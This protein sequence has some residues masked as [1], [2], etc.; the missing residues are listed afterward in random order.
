MSAETRPRSLPRIHRAWPIALVTFLALVATAAFRSSTG[1]LFEPIEQTFGWSRSVTSSAVTLNLVVYGLAAPFA[2]A[3]M[4]RFG[5]RRVGA[6]ALLLV[7]TGSGLTVLM[8][9]VWHLWVLWGLFIGLGTGA[10]ALVF[11][12]IV[13]NRWF[14][15]HRGLVVGL[16]SAGN[17]TGQLIFLPFIATL[18]E[19]GSWRAAALVV[20]VLAFALIPVFLAVMRERPA[21][22]GLA[23]YGAAPEDAAAPASVDDGQPAGAPQSPAAVAV[24]ELRLG[25]R[26]RVFWALLVSFA[27]CGFSTNGLIQ[28]HF[29]PAGHDHGMSTQTSANLL[30]LIGIFDLVGTLASGWL[31]DRV[32]PRKLLFV[33]YSLR[34]VSLMLLPSL[35]SATVE[36]PLFFFIVFYGLDWVATVPPTVALCREHFGIDRAGVVFG[37]VFGAHMIGAGIASGMAGWIREAL[38]DYQLAFLISGVA[39]VLAALVVGSIPRPPQAQPSG[40]RR[41][42]D[43]LPAYE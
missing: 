36:P 27:I 8:T 23:P 24:R 42:D 43:A 41:D 22:V 40:A 2:A 7:G 32:D 4:E 37:W 38:G 30:A 34:G 9:Q 18:I 15:K 14:V 21:D 10:M 26:N 25:M 29:I 6:L 13:A 1:A 28:N 5:V 12:A 33:Y 39:C 11:G 17:A 3:V 16:F 20:T 35:L 19:D 31:T